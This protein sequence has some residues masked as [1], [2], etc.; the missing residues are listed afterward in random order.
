MTAPDA[1]SRLKNMSR[2]LCAPFCWVPPERGRSVRLALRQRPARRTCCT[3]IFAQNR[4]RRIIT[5]Q[6]TASTRTCYLRRSKRCIFKKNRRNAGLGHPDRRRPGP[7]GRPKPT[8]CKLRQQAPS[9][10]RNDSK[11][12]SHKKPLRNRRN[13]EQPFCFLRGRSDG[14]P[15]E[16]FS[17]L[18][19]TAAETNDRPSIT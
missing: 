19:A 4:P 12:S 14:E 2:H 13:E 6:P 17:G 18:G 11:C 8:A 3:A 7:T 1:T 10:W 5:I 9:V 16:D 15:E